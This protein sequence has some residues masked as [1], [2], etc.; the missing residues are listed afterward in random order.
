MYF[1]FFIPGTV[2]LFFLL[3]M[4]GLVYE[5]WNSFVEALPVLLIALAVVAVFSFF[6][7]SLYRKTKNSL[8]VFD[9]LSMPLLTCILGLM[10]MDVVFL[11]RCER[12]FRWPG[13]SMELTI[14]FPFLIIAAA[15][16]LIVVIS[17][18]VPFRSV[19]LV[20]VHLVPVAVFLYCS[21]VATQSWSDFFVSQVE[22]VQS[23]QEY[24]I[25][26][27]TTAYYP[28]AR[29]ENRYP[30]L[31]PLKYTGSSFAEGEIVILLGD[32]DGDTWGEDYIAV[33]DGTRAAVVEKDHL[34]PCAENQYTYAMTVVKDRDIVD[35]YDAV[36]ETHISA[37]DNEPFTLVKPGET[38]I[39]TLSG[40]ETIQ[41]LDMGYDMVQILYQG[42]PAYINR[43]DLCLVRT[44]DHVP[45]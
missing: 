34:H 4:A 19:L 12:L 42:A 32:L 9:A 3:A 39:G 35:V 5:A 13:F 8:Y 23:L 37:L 29:W 24:V 41:V 21:A 26:E 27:K 33:S 40:G 6:I 20:L 31:S 28:G 22:N 2:V 30:S 1:L 43:L 7:R 45:E 17:A 44:A 18:F 16:L 25:T 15:Y 38:I 36:E 10:M 11:D 14:L